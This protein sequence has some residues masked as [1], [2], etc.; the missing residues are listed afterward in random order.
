MSPFFG[1]EGSPTKIDD[2]KNKSGTLIRTSPLDDLVKNKVNHKQCLSS[3]C[4]LLFVVLPIHVG[5]IFIK[6]SFCSWV[7]RSKRGLIPHY[8][9]EHPPGVVFFGRP[10]RKPQPKVQATPSYLGFV[11]GS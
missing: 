4:V 3:E 5:P 2:R 9:Q 11:G 7:F 1:W 8:T 6:S 10:L